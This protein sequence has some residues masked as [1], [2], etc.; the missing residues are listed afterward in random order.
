[1]RLEEILGVS[2]LGNEVVVVYEF[3]NQKYVRSLFF[4]MREYLFI[5]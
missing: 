2:V 1:M 5:L 4:L 3:R